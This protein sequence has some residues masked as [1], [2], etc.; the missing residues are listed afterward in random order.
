MGGKG[1]SVHEACGRGPSGCAGLTRTSASR[2]FKQGPIS[3]G[4]NQ[5]ARAPERSRHP[6]RG[7]REDT[8][9]S[10]G[11]EQGVSGT[12]WPSSSGAEN[13]STPRVLRAGDVPIGR[14]QAG[15]GT[16]ELSGAVRA[17]AHCPGVPNPARDCCFFQEGLVLFVFIFSIKPMFSMEIAPR[18]NFLP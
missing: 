7:G 6:H 12:C 17:T 18:L 15:K 13:P 5:P 1:G 11:L 16:R 8:A 3:K 10:H 14:T 2:P 4:H 9:A